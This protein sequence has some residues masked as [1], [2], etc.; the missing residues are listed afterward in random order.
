MGFRSYRRSR[1]EP[2]PRA[3]SPGSAAELPPPVAGPQSAACDATA[4]SRRSSPLRAPVAAWD[5]VVMGRGVPLVSQHAHLARQSSTLG[6]SLS[7]ADVAT[8]RPSNRCISP[9]PHPHSPH[10]SPHSTLQ[11]V[12]HLFSFSLETWE[13]STLLVLVIKFHTACDQSAVCVC[14]CVC[15]PGI[16]TAALTDLINS[17]TATSKFG[18]LLLP[19][20]GSQS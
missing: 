10:L 19:F 4:A 3:H 20:S 9:P 7:R 5:G 13:F 18:V 14:V 17:S 11:G 15:V 16:L 12:L 1:R 2:P 8:P 6:Q